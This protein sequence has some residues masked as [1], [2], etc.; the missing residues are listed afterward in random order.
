MFLELSNCDHRADL[1]AARAVGLDTIEPLYSLQVDHPIGAD[2]V[3]LKD[4]S[5]S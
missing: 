3:R 4:V 1:Q 2:D 5:R